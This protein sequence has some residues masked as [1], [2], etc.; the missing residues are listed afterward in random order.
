MV[1][2]LLVVSPHLDDGA[3]SAG[4]L[5]AGR[6][7]CLVATVMTAAPARGGMRTTYDRDCGFSSASRALIARRAED[8]AALAVLGA[9]GVHLGFVDHQYREITPM[10]AD[11]GE[12]A[13]ALA[14][15]VDADPLI[16]VAV[17]PLGLAHPDHHL[18][19][20]AFRLLVDARPHL[21]AWIMEDLPSRVL[22]P[23]E[24]PGRLDWWRA[25]GFDPRLDFLGTGDLDEK[26]RAVRCYG[27]QTWALGALHEVLVPERFW[28][29]R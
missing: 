5:M 12:I 16:T 10:A 1:D 6:P 22:W 3:L 24:V 14:G 25:H 9:T 23:E 26:E 2:P 11:A 15:V 18:V 29:L 4:Q 20:D 21:E 28:R 17:G 8:A 7:D 13:E 19:A 27:S